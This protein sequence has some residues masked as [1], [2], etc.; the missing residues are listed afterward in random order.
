MRKAINGI[1]TL[2]GLGVV[3]AVYFFVPLGRYT[4]YEHTLRIAATEPAQE[5]GDEV[6]QA[7]RELGEQALDE[8]QSR[9]SIR[10]GAAGDRSE[11]SPEEDTLRL[12][13]E[14]D[15]VHLGPQ[16]LSPSQ[17]RNR[18]RQARGTATELRA[19]LETAD[20][21]SRARVEELRRLLREEHVAVDAAR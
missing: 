9:E 2:I 15:G 5:L 16:I 7:T 18:I 13:L 4:L 3:L 8:W 19:I 21:V 10:E 20:G 11:G 1:L 12:R 14:D 17:L 6:G